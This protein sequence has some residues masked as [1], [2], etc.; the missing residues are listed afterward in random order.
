MASLQNRRKISER[1]QG[2]LEGHKEEGGVGGRETERKK[3]L[4]L[5]SRP[6]LQKGDDGSFSNGLKSHKTHWGQNIHHL[7]QQENP[8]TA[9]HLNSS[10]AS[11]RPDSSAPILWRRARACREGYSACKKH[12]SLER[13]WLGRGEKMT[14]S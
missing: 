6:W 3:L 2:I 14:V 11:P 8:I 5:P 7:N 1:E 12:K 9:M 4:T 13:P 10:A